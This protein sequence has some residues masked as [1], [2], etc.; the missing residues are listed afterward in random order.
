MKLRLITT[1]LMSFCLSSLMTLWV[2]WLNLGLVPD[3]LE[4]WLQ[5]W[6]SAWPAAFVLVLLLAEPVGKIS[7]VIVAILDGKAP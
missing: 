5:A 4:R 7:R 2:T 1:A 6:L 3:F